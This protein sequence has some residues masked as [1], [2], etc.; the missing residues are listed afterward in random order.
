M[1]NHPNK[2]KRGEK[3]N[4]HHIIWKSANDPFYRHENPQRQIYNVFHPSNVIKMDMVD[5]WFLHA[6]YDTCRTPKE[7]LQK[8]YQIVKHVMSP[9]AK[10]LLL[11][12]LCMSDEEF[13]HD[14]IM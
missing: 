9:Q 1:R 7:E 11:E 6:F 2:I 13:Y 10:E 5:H 8:M 4:R 14:E 3:T 12:L